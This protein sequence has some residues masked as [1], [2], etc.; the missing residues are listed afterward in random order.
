MRR[1]TEIMMWLAGGGF[2]LSFAA[3]A[4]AALLPVAPAETNTL[5]LFAAFVALRA[6]LCATEGDPWA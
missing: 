3:D 5:A 2:L 6:L 4:L 1:L